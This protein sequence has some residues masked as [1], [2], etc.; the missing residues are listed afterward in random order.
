VSASPTDV[1]FYANVGETLSGAAAPTRIEYRVTQDA[2]DV[3]RTTAT[4][5]ETRQSATALS[6]A[7]TG[8]YLWSSGKTRTVSSGI[9]W[10]PASAGVFSFADSSAQALPITVT[11]TDQ[12]TLGRICTVNIALPVGDAAHPSPGVTTS[13][14]LPNSTLGN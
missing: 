7:A 6:A 4:I 5:T 13:V 9:S 12:T 8:G 3:T 11:T 2:T 14:F 10:A 1:V